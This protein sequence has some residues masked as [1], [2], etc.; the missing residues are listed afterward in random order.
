MKQVEFA[1][2]YQKVWWVIM[3]FSMPDYCIK[4]NLELIINLVGKT[5]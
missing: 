5:S 1:R 2:N 3:L 4:W